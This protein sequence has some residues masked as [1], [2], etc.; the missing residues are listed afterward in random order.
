M[1]NLINEKAVIWSIVMEDPERMNL[2]TLSI[3]DGQ[4]MLESG[5]RHN[6][7]DH[8][9]QRKPDVTGFWELLGLTGKSWEEKHFCDPDAS[10]PRFICKESGSHHLSCKPQS[11]C[12]T[13]GPISS[14]QSHS[15]VK[16]CPRHPVWGM[17]L[18]QW[19]CGG[20]TA[21]GQQRGM[22]CTYMDSKSQA[23]QEVKC[24]AVKQASGT[25]SFSWIRPTLRSKAKAAQTGH[26]ITF[27]ASCSFW[28][29]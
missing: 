26:S 9:F 17:A 1:R 3:R 19:L 21:W 13:H 25:E 8:C 28:Q 29:L 20:G 16:P 12:T 18:S 11:S 4:R 7:P 6:S 22:N 5:Q 24:W 23:F 15:A 2:N 10:H 27:E 14:P